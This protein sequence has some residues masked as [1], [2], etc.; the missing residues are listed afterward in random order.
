MSDHLPDVLQ[1]LAR[2][3]GFPRHRLP[4]QAELLLLFAASAGQG[5]GAS[6][7]VGG[8]IQTQNAAMAA[9]QRQLALNRKRVHFKADNRAKV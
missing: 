2:Y 9:S 7:D 1:W 4:A 3:S 5:T 6:D 8:P